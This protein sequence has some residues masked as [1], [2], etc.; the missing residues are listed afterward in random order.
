M[1]C[2][3]VV[4]VVVAVSGSAFSGDMAVP[5]IVV[6]TAAG[7]GDDVTEDAALAPAPDDATAVVVTVGCVCFFCELP[8]DGDA[9]CDRDP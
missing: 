6:V 8:D 1:S 4:V 3:D 5:T 9:W 2:P 7:D